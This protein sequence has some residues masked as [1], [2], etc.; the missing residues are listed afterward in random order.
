MNKREKAI[1][2]LLVSVSVLLLLVFANNIQIGLFGSSSYNKINEKTDDFKDSIQESVDY[3]I[4]IENTGI[5]DLCDAYALNT[6]EMKEKTR[7]EATSDSTESK[8]K[9]FMEHHK[10][11]NPHQPLSSIRGRSIPLIE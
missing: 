8:L 2:N 9:N 10:I 1:W 6:D 7:Q 4:D 3:K 11:I 5:V